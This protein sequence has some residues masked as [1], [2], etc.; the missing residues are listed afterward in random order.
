MVSRGRS[1]GTTGM[2]KKR[3]REVPSLGSSGIC[4]RNTKWNRIQAWQILSWIS[5]LI[6]WTSWQWKRC[7]PLLPRTKVNTKYTAVTSVITKPCINPYTSKETIMTWYLFYHIQMIKIHCK[8][9]GLCLSLGAQSF[10]HASVLSEKI[11][12][13]ALGGPEVAIFGPNDLHPMY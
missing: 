7:R 10:E 9:G 4:S 13:S 1:Q 2:E 11:N 12:F 8:L 6:L 5:S 3:P